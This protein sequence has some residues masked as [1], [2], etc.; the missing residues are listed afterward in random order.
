MA[1]SAK[2]TEGPMPNEA[3]ESFGFY[4]LSQSTLTSRSLYLFLLDYYK[5]VDLFYFTISLAHNADNAALTA[6]KALILNAKD[7]EERMRYQYNIDNP[8]RAVKKLNDFGVLNSRNLTVTTVN[9]FLWFVSA[10]I[11]GA[12]KKRPEMVK[13]GEL[14]KIEDIFEFNNKK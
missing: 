3:K 11:Q 8:E 2:Q 13:S 12:M 7:E 6:S 10:T 1:Q 4:F 14:V 5:V 9:S